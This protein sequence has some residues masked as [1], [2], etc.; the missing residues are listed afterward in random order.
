MLLES[1]EISTATRVND[2]RSDPAPLKAWTDSSSSWP[3]VYGKALHQGITQIKH[4]S[5]AAES[6]VS[7]MWQYP[8]SC[9]RLRRAN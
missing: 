3:I 9:G 1:A 2:P 4:L 8:S 5:T 7:C 6:L